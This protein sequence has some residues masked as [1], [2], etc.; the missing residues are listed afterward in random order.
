M[1]SLKF[2]LTLGLGMLT[3]CAVN[4]S[5]NSQTIE[6]EIDYRGAQCGMMMAGDGFTDTAALLPAIRES[7]AKR[8][9]LIVSQEAPYRCV[10][11]LVFELQ[12]QRYE[13]TFGAEPPSS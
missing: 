11:P 7:G 3:S 12:R 9:L 4:Q 2:W 13:V 6:V 10:G 5:R 8:V 1:N